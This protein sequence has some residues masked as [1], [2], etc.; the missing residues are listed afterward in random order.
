MKQRKPYKRTT[1]PCPNMLMKSKVRLDSLPEW[2]HERL[3]FKTVEDAES[4]F[5][6]TEPQRKNFDRWF[7]E[8]N[9]KIKE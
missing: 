6:N 3:V 4:Y 1:H 7:E 8:C 5:K 9:I 2:E